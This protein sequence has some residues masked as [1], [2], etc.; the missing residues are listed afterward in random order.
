VRLKGNG[1]MSLN[2]GSAKTHHNMRFP[3]TTAFDF[4][5]SKRQ[6]WNARHYTWEDEK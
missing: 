2:S 5:F 3:F 4:Q 6:V 1:L